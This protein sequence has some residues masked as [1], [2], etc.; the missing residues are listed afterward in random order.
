V[1]EKLGPIAAGGTVFGIARA[2]TGQILLATGAGILEQSAAG[3]SPIPQS[4]PLPAT[5]ALCAAG[6]RWWAA[7][8][9]GGMVRSRNQGAS[10]QF[11]W[12]D[13]V[14]EPVTCFAVSPRYS[15]D[16]TLLAGTNGAGVLRSIDRGRRWF[17]SNF[18]LQEFTILALAPAGD[19]SRR[20][21]LFAGTLAGV[22]RSSG[23]GRAWKLAGLEDMAV[24]AL[25]AS[26]CFDKNGLIIA[27][28]EM[29]GLYRSA[30]G[31]RSW[32]H[33]AGD[34]PDEFTVNVLL[35]SLEP[36]SGQEIWLAGADDGGLWRSID[37][38]QQWRQVL[39]GNDPVLSLAGDANQLWA[40]LSG[41]GL[42]SSNDGG[43]SWETVP[44]FLGYG[45]QRLRGD[46]QGRLFVIAPN[47]GVWLSLDQGQN[48]TQALEASLGQPLFD[49]AA[50]GEG[51]LAAWPD[52]LWQRSGDDEW[53]PVIPAEEGQI[54]ALA[55]NDL[56]G[57]PIWAATPDCQLRL[58]L[59]AGLTWQMVRTPFTGQQ[60]LA[61]AMSPEDAS[62]VVVSLDGR[63]SELSVWRWREDGGGWEAWFNWPV[64]ASPYIRLAVAGPQARASRLIVN[65]E[66]WACVSGSWQKIAGFDQTIRQVTS[67]PTGQPVFVL[68]GYDVL[69]KLDGKWEAL[70]LAGDMPE[71]IDIQVGP[72]GELFG[73]DVTGTVWRYR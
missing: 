22:Y 2:E 44:D 60:L 41:Q 31:G 61:L 7:G 6:S 10:W 40:G 43:Q 19:W 15:S 9:S 3:W 8:L 71:L 49:F 45:F 51:W 30:D 55:G 50:T 32:Q 20:E 34:F 4:R 21:Y 13:Q 69:A 14:T 46:R 12:L 65:Q 27:G 35:N 36:D 54:V 62:L 37:G 52:G 39:E 42:L 17:L 11:C 24:Q 58:S 47:D 53:Q 29:N 57:S 25:A 26:R 72:G 59:D 1:W 56:P 73:L 68:V 5:N 23:G 70:I 48:W 66:L 16:G 64:P 33:V 18:G 67:G 28:T 63:R 38:G